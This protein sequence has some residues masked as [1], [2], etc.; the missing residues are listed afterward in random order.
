[1]NTKFFFLL[2]VSLLVSTST[3]SLVAGKFEVTATGEK[4][5]TPDV[6]KHS[7]GPLDVPLSNWTP[8]PSKIHHDSKMPLQ[9][10]DGKHHHFHFSRVDS[11]RRRKNLHR[12]ICKIVL[13]I[14][15]ISC[16]I[17]CYMHAFH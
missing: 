13:T 10:E 5:H 9:P 17:Y 8:D 11:V 15:H 4:Q 3:S 12:M 2:L 14:A 16:F 6:D 1:M 7:E